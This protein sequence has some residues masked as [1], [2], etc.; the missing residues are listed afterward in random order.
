VKWRFHIAGAPGPI[1][2]F[3]LGKGQRCLGEGG[4]K[5]GRY[6]TGGHEAGT[7]PRD[8]ETSVRL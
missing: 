8:A 7:L 5:L 1:L 3:V 6:V 2:L 4:K